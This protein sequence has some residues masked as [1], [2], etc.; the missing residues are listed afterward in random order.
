MQ[1]KLLILS[2][3]VLLLEGCNGIGDEWFGKLVGAFAPQRDDLNETKQLIQ[4]LATTKG[5]SG[6]LVGVVYKDTPDKVRH[7]RET[8]FPLEPLNTTSLKDPENKARFDRLRALSQKLSLKE[9]TVDELNRVWV[10]MYQG[11]DVVYGYVFFDSGNGQ[12]PEAGTYL[13]IPGE[14]KWHVF[15][16]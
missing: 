2:M 1:N 11:R 7:P 12:T 4:T 8:P 15:R 16:R 5:I 3:I 14:K 13:A 6:F 9:I 10:F